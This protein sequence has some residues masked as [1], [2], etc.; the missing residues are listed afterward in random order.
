MSK[1]SEILIMDSHVLHSYQYAGW[2]ILSEVIQH[3]GDV[4]VFRS[5]VDEVVG[6]NVEK[7]KE[8]GLRFV[9]E[10]PERRDAFS[11]KH[12]G[13][14]SQDHVRLRVA[15]ALGY[16]CVV[17]D[18]AIRRACEAEGLIVFLGKHL[19]QELV[20]RKKMTAESCIQA[21]EMMHIFNGQELSRNNID[22]FVDQVRGI[23]KAS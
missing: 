18:E 21:A 16:M 8:L 9:E 22:R 7:C 19:L 23:S 17:E 12:N 1:R 4:Y 6:V 11:F 5:V 3:L 20:H 14:S 13:L 10:N 15:V 2:P